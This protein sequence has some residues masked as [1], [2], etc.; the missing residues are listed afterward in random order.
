MATSNTPTP[1]TANDQ[2]QAIEAK[3]LGVWPLDESNAVLLNE[4]HPRGYVQSV[5][6]QETHEIYDLLVI[7][8]GAGGLV[9]SRQVRL[10]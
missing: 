1:W 7:G 2:N 4:V 6:A 8:A 5:A 10:V 9:S 3:E